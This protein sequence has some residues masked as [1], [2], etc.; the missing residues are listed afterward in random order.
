MHHFIFLT[1][2]GFFQ[3][4]CVH[5]ICSITQSYYLGLISNRNALGGN[6][7][8]FENDEMETFQL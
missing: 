2:S 1:L 4:Q 6:N 3:V 8:H 7:T 5:R